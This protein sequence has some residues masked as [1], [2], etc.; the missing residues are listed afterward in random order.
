MTLAERLSASEAILPRYRDASLV[1]VAASILDA[2]GARRD[3]D[4]EPVRG[5]DADALR[6]ADAVV[7][8]LV[9]GL[10]DTQLRAA[11]E[12]R[13]VPYLGEL[14]AMPQRPSLTSIFPSSTVSALGSLDTA[15]PP[16]AHGLVAYQHWLEEF[17]CVAQMLRWGPADRNASFADAPW[18]ADARGFVPI[19]TVDARLARA[20]VARFL[21]QPAIFKNS[22]LVRMLSPDST[23]VPYLAT[24]S[25]AVVTRRLLRSRQW[26]EG[27]AFAFVY[28]ST[29]D[30]VAH[31][32][33]PRSEEHHA[34]LRAIDRGLVAPGS[35][36]YW[37]T[38]IQSELAAHLGSH[39][40]L[41]RDEMAI[42]LLAW[43]S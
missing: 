2:F 19:E 18:N 26:G 24:S 34:E 43:T 21:I 22:P 40:A 20:G 12:R 27:R 41:T 6:E 39:G 38:F 7:L 33:G 9:D 15:R 23:Y 28:W 4:P 11:I 5:L 13:D 16:G 35:S 32:I 10:G 31:F 17:G 25:A 30:T 1:N 3:D 14:Y 29:L 42:P 37:Y 8:V 36:Q